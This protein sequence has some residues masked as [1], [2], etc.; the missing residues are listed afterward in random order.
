MRPLPRA[1]LVAFLTYGPSPLD[2]VHSKNH[3]PEGLIP[4]GLRLILISC[5]VK[6]IEKT[7]TGTWHFVN[8]LVPKND[9]SRKMIDVSE[10]NIP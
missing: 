3:V 5:D 2:D 6:N 4:F 9:I 10:G 8:R 1:F 7:T